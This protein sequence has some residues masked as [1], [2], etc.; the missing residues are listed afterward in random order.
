MRED[1]GLVPYM[2]VIRRLG[3]IFVILVGCVG[4]D[5]SSK[6]AA[7]LFLEGR[8][9]IS[10][11]GNALRFSYV[12]NTGGFLGLGATL[13]VHWRTGIFLG[14]AALVLGALLAY[15]ILKKDIGATTVLGVTLVVGGGL[16]NIIDRIANGGHVV[17]FLNVGVGPLRTGIFNVADMAVVLG[18]LI[19]M[20]AAGRWRGSGA[21]NDG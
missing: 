5:Q 13:P 17:D 15:V 20:V 21:E 8:E 11:F 3:V 12:E 9:P 4:C 7:R 6:H 19:L 16:G 10:M 18:V 1:D 2:S 14:A